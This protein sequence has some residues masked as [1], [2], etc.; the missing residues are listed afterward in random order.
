MIHPGVSVGDDDELVA[1]YDAPG[2]SEPE[3]PGAL[4]ARRCQGCAVVEAAQEEGSFCGEGGLKFRSCGFTGSPLREGQCE[5][6]GLWL[7]SSLEAFCSRLAAVMKA[8]DEA[9]VAEEARGQVASLV[10]ADA[11]A[12]RDA[13]TS[14]DGVPPV[15]SFLPPQNCFTAALKLALDDASSICRSKPALSSAVRPP[16]GTPPR[17]RRRPST[18]QTL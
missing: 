8:A 16:R 15:C 11:L 4:G 17:R 6:C 9:R 1:L 18:C 5:G 12:E 13:A 10:G 2:A 7:G 14:S 3:W